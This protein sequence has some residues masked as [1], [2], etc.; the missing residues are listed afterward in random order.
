MGYW[1][2]AAMCL[3]GEFAPDAIVSFLTV[4]AAN[5]SDTM[6]GC[7]VE[8]K[9]LSQDWSRRGEQFRRARLGARHRTRERRRSRVHLHRKRKCEEGLISFSKTALRDT[10]PGLV[11]LSILVQNVMMK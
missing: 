7:H 9:V 10:S 2:I 6:P 4:H 1:G 11:C 8:T 3:F 5:R